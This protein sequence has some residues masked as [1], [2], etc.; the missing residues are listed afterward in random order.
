MEMERLENIIIRKAN[1]KDFDCV[2]DLASQLWETEQPFDQNIKAGY[3]QTESGQK[4]LL[5]GMKSRK[6]IFLVAVIDEKVVGFIY[7]YVSDQQ[8]SVVEK[9]AYASLLCVDK[10]NRK[11]GIGTKLMD[12][13]TNLVKEK[14]AGYIKLNAFADN[15]P[16]VELYH[17]KGFEL[18]SVF[19]RKKIDR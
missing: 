10:S 11:K 7:G 5:K 14:G 15:I 18:Y 6:S 19:Y 12:E 1:K 4:E 16:A 17:K 3:F 8:D 13:F 9:V 2:V